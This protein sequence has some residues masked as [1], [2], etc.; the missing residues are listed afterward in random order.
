MA[1]KT[2][3]TV[4]VT[5]LALVNLFLKLMQQLCGAFL[6]VTCESPLLKP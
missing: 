6:R 4:H 2:T 3:G 5:I 1:D